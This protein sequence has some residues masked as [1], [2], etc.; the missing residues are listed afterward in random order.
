MLAKENGLIDVLQATDCATVLRTKSI[1]AAF[2]TRN[3]VFTVTFS[4]ICRASVALFLFVPLQDFLC[5]PSHCS[6]GTEPLS[7]YLMMILSM[8][9]L[10]E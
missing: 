2:Q 9:N 7:S 1:S 6:R 10:S 4:P 3:F 5:S 8:T